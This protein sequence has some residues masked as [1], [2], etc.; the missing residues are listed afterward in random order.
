M[1]LQVLVDYY[2]CIALVTKRVLLLAQNL[3]VVK[4]G[5][6]VSDAFLCSY[7]LSYCYAN[8]LAMHFCRQQNL[9][10][11]LLLGSGRVVAQFCYDYCY[12]VSLPQLSFAI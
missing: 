5:V 2:S 11:L 7:G 4:V 10:S 6:C 8:C 9:A 3:P 12:Q 1:C